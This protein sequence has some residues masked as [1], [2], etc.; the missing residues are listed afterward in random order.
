M[1]LDAHISDDEQITSPVMHHSQAI[2]QTELKVRGLPADISVRSSSDMYTQPPG[3]MASSGLRQPTNFMTCAD[4][5][6]HCDVILTL[7]DVIA[8]RLPGGSMHRRC[9]KSQVTSQHHKGT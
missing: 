3:S 4:P 9:S 6:P 8:R 7:R 1:H 5:F 2:A